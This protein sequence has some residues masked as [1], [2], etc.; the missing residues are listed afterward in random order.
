MVVAKI[1]GRNRISGTRKKFNN[2]IKYTEFARVFA[3][4]LGYD[5]E[6]MKGSEFAP[7]F[8]VSKYMTDGLDW[9][10]L[11]DE[12]EDRFGLS[13]IESEIWDRL[14]G[15]P[16]ANRGVCPKLKLFQ[17]FM[18]ISEIPKRNK[19]DILKNRNRPVPKIIEEREEL[20][21]IIARQVPMFQGAEE[22][23]PDSYRLSLSPHAWFFLLSDLEKHAKSNGYTISLD[24]YYDLIEDR[25][26][27][28]VAD[29]FTLA[30]KAKGSKKYSKSPKK[31]FSQALAEIVAKYEMTGT[32]Y[33]TLTIM[34][35]I[36]L[37]LDLETLS[38]LYEFNLDMDD[39]FDFLQ[40]N[41]NRIKVEDFIDFVG[42]YYSNCC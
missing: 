10:D 6:R 15:R 13:Y 28:V 4:Y 21:M 8:K 14:G 42:I 33:L 22:H 41:E 16:T 37:Y 31:I 23:L 36:W 17:L 19:R 18:F 1:F 5:F 9:F 12:F 2:G 26:S 20:R 30:N 38:P 24:S 32:A 3:D 29:I 35:G 40:Q 11:I 27:I 7:D 39:F 34:S 25:Q